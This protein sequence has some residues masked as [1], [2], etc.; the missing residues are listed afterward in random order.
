LGGEND[1]TKLYNPWETSVKKKE[2]NDHSSPHKRGEK[3]SELPV[4]TKGKRGWG[5]EVIR[6][7]ER[8]GGGTEGLF[9]RK[10]KDFK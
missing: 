10:K 2:K 8:K 6:K 7:A 5:V 9:S 1:L 4:N 3:K